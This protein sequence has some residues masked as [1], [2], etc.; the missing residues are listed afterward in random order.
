M[1]TEHSVLIQVR[2]TVDTPRGPY[3]DALYFTEEA[4]AKR[5]EQVIEAAKQARADNWLNV[6]T[7]PP[8]SETKEDMQARNDALA[9]Q[10]A[11]LV[12]EKDTL[13]LEIV[14]SG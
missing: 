6:V 8:R 1:P 14:E 4:W 9:Q 12:V 13:A 10:I 3:S 5:D 2:F 7:A 11:E